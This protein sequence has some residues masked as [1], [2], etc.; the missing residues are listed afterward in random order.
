M[1]SPLPSSQHAAPLTPLRNMQFLTLMSILV[2]SLIMLTSVEALCYFGNEK[3]ECG[4]LEDCVS[5]K[6]CMSGNCSLASAKTVPYD[7]GEWKI[8]FCKCKPGNKNRKCEYGEECLLD[9]DWAGPM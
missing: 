7:G 8:G 9:Q 4:K 3:G 2:V 5:D 6:D 1:G